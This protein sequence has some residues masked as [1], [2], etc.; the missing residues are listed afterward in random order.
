MHVLYITVVKK[1]IHFI[2]NLVVGHVNHMIIESFSLEMP[3]ADN[4]GLY[5]MILV[6]E[7]VIL[8]FFN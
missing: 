3:P 4:L 5:N 7:T 6:R 1:K 8:E 2:C